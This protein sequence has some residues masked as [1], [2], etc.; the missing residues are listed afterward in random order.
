MDFGYH[1]HGAQNVLVTNP[2]KGVMSYVFEMFLTKAFQKHMTCPKFWSPPNSGGVLD[3]DLF[4]HK[5]AW[6]DDFFSKMILHGPFS[7]AME[8]FQS[9]SDI[10]PLSNG[11]FFGH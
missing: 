5:T 3:G 8:N 2:R 6:G 4:G 7:L 9:P 1:A 11:Q 10:P